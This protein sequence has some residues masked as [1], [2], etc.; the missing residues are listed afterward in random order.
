MSSSIYLGFLYA[1]F[2]SLFFILMSSVV[3]KRLHRN[4]HFIQFSRFLLIQYCYVF[5]L[6]MCRLYFCIFAVICA[7]SVL[8]FC[9]LLA[10]QPMLSAYC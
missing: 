6:L 1:A 4:L 9:T 8:M 2:A 5:P 3:L 10:A 7:S